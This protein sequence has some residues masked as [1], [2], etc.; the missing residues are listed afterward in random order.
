MAY[1][2][3]VPDVLKFAVIRDL[4]AKGHSQMAVQSAAKAIEPYDEN[5]LLEQ[6]ARGNVCITFVEDG[7]ALPELLAVE[8]ADLFRETVE[9]GETGRP[10]SHLKVDRV[11]H[12]LLRLIA[13]GAE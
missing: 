4:T 12:K 6:F 8:R 7:L 9:R 10:I 11:Y 2:W 1:L 5:S 13:E 3:L